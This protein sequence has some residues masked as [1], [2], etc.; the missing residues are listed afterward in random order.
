[1]M[2]TAKKVFVFIAILIFLL[3]AAMFGMQAY[4]C[5]DYF[6]HSDC[7]NGGCTN[8]DKAESCYLYGCDPDGSRTSC[9]L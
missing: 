2:T 1:M 6:N 8:P 5:K 4:K 9:S 3:G 7:Q